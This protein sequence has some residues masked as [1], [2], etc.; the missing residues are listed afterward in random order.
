MSIYIAHRRRKTSNALINMFL[1]IGF[2]RCLQALVHWCGFHARS[3]SEWCKSLWSLAAQTVAARHL[4]S[5]GRLLLPAH[6]ECVRALSCCDTRH[7]T[8][9]QIWRPSRPDL[10]F[11]N[12]RL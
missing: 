5:C 6:H 2:S 7:R 1:C 4:S 10:N 3:D 8:W 12:Y 11:I 9:H